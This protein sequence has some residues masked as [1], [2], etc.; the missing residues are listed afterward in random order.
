MI[1]N[2]IEYGDMQLIAEAYDILHRGLGLSAEELHQVFSRWNDG[3]LSSYL[4]EITSD[5]F[6]VTDRET[7]QPLVSRS[8]ILQRKREQESGPVR[9]HSIWEFLSLQSMPP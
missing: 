8:L 9:M 5:I 1:H 3:P 2:A 4:I 6:R 7:N